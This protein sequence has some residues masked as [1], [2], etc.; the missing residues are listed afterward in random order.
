MVW[1]LILIVSAISVVLFGLTKIFKSFSSHNSK[2]QPLIKDDKVFDGARGHHGTIRKLII[3]VFGEE[4]EGLDPNRISFC[5]AHYFLGVCDYFSQKDQ[6]DDRQFTDF[7]FAMAQGY[8]PTYFGHKHIEAAL[9]TLKGNT[10]DTNIWM[11]FV[12]LG[13]QTA[14]EFGEADKDYLFLVQ[15]TFNRLIHELLLKNQP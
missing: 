7:L 4:P 1:E 14:H 11:P 3:N 10:A 13:G 8:D 12:R 9:E 2:L 5:R 15:V 6:M